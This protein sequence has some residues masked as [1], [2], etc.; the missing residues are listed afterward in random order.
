[1]RCLTS[2]QGNR[3]GHMLTL[4][5]RHRCGHMLTLQQRPKGD[6]LTLL[7]ADAFNT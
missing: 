5:Q 2:Q 1:M 4:Q 7:Y 3:G 6:M